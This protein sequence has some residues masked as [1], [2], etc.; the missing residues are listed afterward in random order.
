M[1]NNLFNGLQVV[2]GEVK[3]E[4]LN[5]STDISISLRGEVSLTKS[6]FEQT[7][8]YWVNNCE[9]TRYGLVDCDDYDYEQN[10]TKLGGLPIDSLHQ[11]KQ[12]LQTSGLTTL[13]NSLGFDDAEV[14][15]SMF[16]AVENSKGFKKQ[17]GKNAKFWRALSN[18]EQKLVK[19]SY[20]IDNYDTCHEHDKRQFGIKS[21]DDEGEEIKNYVPTFEELKMLKQTLTEL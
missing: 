1:T 6:N 8:T 11:L 4:L 13:A 17:F 12:T 18:A 2:S 15:N 10:D 20:A 14:K 5:E 3:T 9:M 7:F 21:Y 16:L 19:L